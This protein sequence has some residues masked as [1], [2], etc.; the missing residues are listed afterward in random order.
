MHYSYFLVKPDGVKFLDKICEDVEKRYESVRYY[1][2]S[3]FETIIKKLYHKHYEKGGEKFAT[4]FES[5]L[6]GLKELFGNESVLILIG[7]N[8]RTYE[9]LMKSVLDMKFEIRDK[10]VNNNVAIV[11]NYG[12]REEYIRIISSNGIKEPRIMN[13]EGSYRISDMNIIHC[14]DSIKAETL[15]ELNILMTEGIIDDKNLITYDMI[16]MMKKYKT[17]NFQKDMREDNYV[18]EFKPDISGWLKENI[19]EDMDER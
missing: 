7:D 12:E 5:Y 13:S 16:K 4:S 18:G 11:T 3:D 17:V 15:D 8:R 10:Y 14:P 9:E 2:V 6:Y 1:A 19:K